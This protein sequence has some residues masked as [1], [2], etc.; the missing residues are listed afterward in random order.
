MSNETQ[1]IEKRIDKSVTSEISVGARGG[2]SYSNAGQVMELAKMMAVAEVAVPAH[3]R[4][5]P[6]ACLAV[7]FQALD[8]GMSPFAVANKSY[9]VNN[10]MA[11][12]SQMINAVILNRAPIVG[13]FKISYDGEGE[14]LTCTVVA[15]G[16]DGEEYPYTSP[17]LGKI[18]VK[19]SP[20]WKS[21][22]RQQLFYYS[23]RALCRRHFPDV[24]LGVYTP[25][26]LDEA[27]ERDITPPK[28][29]AQER[30]QA[31]LA[32]NAQQEP[33]NA[34]TGTPE[35]K[36]SPPAEEPPFTDADVLPPEEEQSQE[37]AEGVD[38]VLTD[39][40]LSI[41]EMTEAGELVKA[42]EQSVDF[43]TLDK[44]DTAKN[45]ILKRAN[46]LGFKWDKKEGTFISE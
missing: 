28:Q 32:Q 23:S 18:P 42:R 14:K 45:A 31:R 17:E 20:L 19:N 41:G 12:E 44:Q 16:T 40:L 37:P 15:K 26:E 34:S 8:W 6:G 7:A 43:D 22:P 39:F 36:A 25:E 4:G 30:L 13:R 29:T 11:Y 38:E 5:N 24:I 3:L 9:S 35:A 1:L 27:P 10:R 2:I 21:D 46:A 33:E